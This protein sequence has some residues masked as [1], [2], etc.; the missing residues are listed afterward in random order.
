M[1]FGKK[2]AAAAALALAIAPVA[3]QA[4]EAKSKPVASKSNRL[5]LTS[6]AEKKMG[7]GSLGIGLAALLAALVVAGIVIASGDDDNSPTSP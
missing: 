4:V 6:K 2:I 7:G 5:G 3:A 1:R